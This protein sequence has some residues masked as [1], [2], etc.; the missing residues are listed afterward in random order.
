MTPFD[1]HVPTR[2]VFGSG[3]LD[4]LGPLARELG[5]ARP[6]LVS[7]R[8]LEEAG[9]VDRALGLLQDAGLEAAVFDD[10]D[11]NPDAAMVGT[12]RRVRPGTPAGLGDRPGRRQLAGLRQ[13]DQSAADERR[14]HGRLPRLRARAQA[15]AADDCRP[16]HRRHRIGSAELRGHRRRRDPHEDGVRRSAARLPGGRSRPGPHPVAAGRRHR[17]GRFRC[18]SRTR[19][20]PR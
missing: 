8:G 16:H 9:H 2:L 15:A 6:L 11:V 5:F 20:R 14:R 18:D 10:F 17:R 19:W 3:T 7:D 4:R 13:G 1:F 12:G